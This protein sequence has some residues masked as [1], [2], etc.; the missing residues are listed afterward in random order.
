LRWKR[1]AAKAKGYDS[2]PMIGFDPVNVAEIITLP[3]DHVIG[4]MI[5]V[6]SGHGS[7]AKIVAVDGMDDEAIQALFPREKPGQSGG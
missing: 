3:S 5:A 2:C 7:P 4:G 6:V 1:S